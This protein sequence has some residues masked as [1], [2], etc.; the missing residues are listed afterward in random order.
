MTADAIVTEIDPG[1]PP[2]WLLDYLQET[3]RLF[4]VGDEWHIFPVMVEQPGEKEFNGE[5]NYDTAYL[6]A[7]IKFDD[8]LKNDD[9]G[10]QVI[11]HE[12]LHVAL[13]E[14]WQTFDYLCGRLPKK[15]RKLARRIWHDAE[16]R[17]IQRTVRAMHLQIRPVA[18]SNNGQEKAQ[19]QDN[20]GIAQTTSSY[21]LAGSAGNNQANNTGQP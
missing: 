18:R 3:R 12:V 19:T 2:T 16:E 6:N 4:G 5:T 10:Q 11:M 14:L 9:E 8:E 21:H 15:E 13:W 1:R 17:T 20:Q 7:T